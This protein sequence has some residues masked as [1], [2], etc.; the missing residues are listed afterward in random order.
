VRTKWS[1]WSSWA[2]AV[3]IISPLGACEPREGPATGGNTP[4]GGTGEEGAGVSG[5]TTP[6]SGEGDLRTDLSDIPVV[7]E[8]WVS[9][10]DTTSNLDSPAFWSGA[11]GD[12]VIA[13]AKGTHDL[14]I[15]DASRGELLRRFGHQ[16]SGLGEFQ[17]P[18]GIAVL[19]DLLFVVERD[20]HRVQ[21]LR[22][23]A[24]E[25]V[26][27][28]GGSSLIR[29]YGIA[30]YGD[31]GR[32]MNVYVTDDYGNEEDPPEGEDPVGD[33]SHRVKHFRLVVRERGLEADLARQFGEAEGP[34]ALLVVESIQ[35]DEVHGNLLVADEHN[36]ELELYGLDGSYK[37]QT[38]GSGLY[39][40]GDPEGIM[41][42]RCGPAG[43]WVLTDQ[44]EDRTV[45]HVL[46][47]IS[48]T[49]V[50]SFTGRTTANTDGIWLTQ[51]PIPNLG[52]G[53]LFALNDD[54]GV[55]AFAWEDVAAA[56]HLHTVCPGS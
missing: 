36:L 11:E 46:D 49:P 27:V 9:A 43:Y 50:G 2:L 30:L 17:Y 52:Q 1:R 29:P 41:L 39:R 26:G 16:G 3:L 28:F 6:S 25:P 22:L 24:F 56:L 14:W 53:A 44:G 20:N 47:R 12:W 21:L 31:P 4:I 37:G 40:F 7:P 34:G 5:A 54:G 8:R 45:F 42:Y 48:F 19:D 10:W 32:E 15:Y 35:V 51:D 38:V 13:T 33:F 18:N 23:P 55:A